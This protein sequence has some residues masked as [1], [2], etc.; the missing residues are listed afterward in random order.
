MS[1]SGVGGLGAEAL[2]SLLQTQKQNEA[3]GTRPAPPSGEMGPQQLW[4]DIEES[5]ETAGLNTEEVAELKS[6]LRDATS[7]AIG[8]VDGTQDP[9]AAREA[10]DG[11]I[12][13]TLQAYG[14]DTTEVEGRM[15]EAKNRMQNGPPPGGPPPP[16]SASEDESE[17]SDT[18][19]IGSSLLST[20]GI[21]QDDASSLLS[22]LF[23]LVDEEA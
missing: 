3:E 9:E 17:S 16:D 23:P 1:V 19:E 20:L 21:G 8:S 6:S 14:V 4:T 2:Q 11:A 10:I 5:A 15:E 22:T 12:L 18:S 13:S 7:S